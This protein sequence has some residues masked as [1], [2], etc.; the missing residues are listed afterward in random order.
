MVTIL[1]SCPWNRQQAKPAAGQVDARERGLDERED[2]AAA[3]DAQL[4][5]RETDVEKHEE[6]ASAVLDVAAEVADGHVVLTEPASAAASESDVA[7]GAKRGALARSLF[8][9]ALAR[10][11]EQAQSEANDDLASAYREIVAADDFIVEIAAKLPAVA[12]NAIVERRRSLSVRIL[13]LRNTL[14]KLI[15]NADRD[16]RDP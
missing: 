8:A 4:D 14:K 3:R 12:R 6:E 16:D 7:D 2:G 13:A 11:R 1:S 9:R 5:R 10:L 15:P